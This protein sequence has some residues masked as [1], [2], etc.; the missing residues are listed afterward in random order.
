MFTIA[1]VAGLFL[2]AMLAG[3]DLLLSGISSEELRRM[4]LKE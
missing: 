1:V 3:A 4:G 2:L